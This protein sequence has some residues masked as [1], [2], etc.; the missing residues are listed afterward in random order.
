MA[1]RMVDAGL[2]R[3]SS[4]APPT[5]TQ[6]LS[7]EVEPPPASSPASSSSPPA[8]TVPAGGQ[9]ERS[10]RT[11]TCPRFHLLARWSCCPSRVLRSP[12]CRTSSQLRSGRG[13]G[14]PRKKRA[15]T[16]GR[17][18]S[19]NGRRPRSAASVESSRRTGG[20]LIGCRRSNALARSIP[21]SGASSGA[22]SKLSSSG[23]S[24]PTPLRGGSG[25]SAG[26]P[27]VSE[28]GCSNRSLS[29]PGLVED[30]ELIFRMNPA[31][32]SARPP[33]SFARVVPLPE[34]P[35]PSCDGHSRHGKAQETSSADR[36]GWA[37]SKPMGIGAR[38]GRRRCSESQ[39]ADHR[40]GAYGLG[41]LEDE[42]AAANTVG[43][44]T[45]RRDLLIRTG[46]PQCAIEF[47][48]GYQ[49][50]KFEKID[51]TFRS[52]GIPYTVRGMRTDT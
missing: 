40:P 51:R 35:Q 41:L 12:R 14:R 37:S 31:G 26:S 2:Q 29:W 32:G 33:A 23:R 48:G 21:R 34:H 3:R 30:V 36:P 39:A 13:R 20:G 9:T 8:V 4:I 42:L 52:L 15:R 11:R 5:G 47:A 19:L 25:A 45:G 17:N 18:C 10:A 16:A 50:E 49:A 7:V 22:L 28:R 27:S 44:T 38:P 24:S 1:R 6:S 43:G 46:E